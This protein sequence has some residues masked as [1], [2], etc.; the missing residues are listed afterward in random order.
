MRL[1]IFSSNQLFV[2]TLSACICERVKKWQVVLC[3]NFGDLEK[4][5]LQEQC[6]VLIDFASEN[7]LE[8]VKKISSHCH[9]VCFVALSV[10][11]V[12]VD[13]LACVDAGFA[14]YVPKNSSVKQ[15]IKI[16]EL[17]E[18]GEFSCNAKIASMLVSEIKRR[19]QQDYVKPIESSPNLDN[20]HSLTPRERE[21]V[22]L[23]HKG[24]SNKEIANSL[25]VSASTVKNHLNKIFAKFDVNRR[26]EVIALLNKSVSDISCPNPPAS[27]SVALSNTI[28][29]AS[30]V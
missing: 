5:I 13:V 19:N 16:L 12:D 15:L 20:I 21:V 27:Y 7:A 8:Y 9:K 3:L 28:K 23:L 1:V 11:E 4:N 22:L 30:S 14:A 2:E 29:L 26:A 25:C 6:I 18:K 17:A 24:F 10:P